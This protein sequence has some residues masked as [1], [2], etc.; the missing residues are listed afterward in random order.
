[1]F[2]AIFLFLLLCFIVVAARGGR[3]TVST[4]VRRH[5]RYRKTAQRVL[6]RLPQ[7][8]SDGARLS[9]LRK[10]NPYVFEEL[11]LLALENRDWRSSEIVPTAV[12]AVWTGRSLLM[13]SAG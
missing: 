13:V 4:R 3:R 5:R 11:L 7:L 8:S 6:G 2:M 9:Y 12:M 1:M 10:I